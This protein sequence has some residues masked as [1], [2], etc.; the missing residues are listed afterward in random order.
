MTVLVSRVLAARRSRLRALPS[1][2]LKKTRDYSQSN[3]THQATQ[4][5]S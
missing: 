3:K 1:L 4:D 5:F 2:N